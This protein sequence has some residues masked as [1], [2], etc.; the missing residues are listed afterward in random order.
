MV[1]A[2]AHDVLQFGRFGEVAER[3]ALSA[4]AAETRLG[5]LCCGLGGIGYALL[6]SLRHID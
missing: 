3:A 5:T 1:F 6:P 2:L 4:W